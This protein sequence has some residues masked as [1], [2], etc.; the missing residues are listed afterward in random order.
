METPLIMVFLDGQMFTPD[1]G[2]PLWVEL[3]INK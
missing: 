3:A 2:L 1:L